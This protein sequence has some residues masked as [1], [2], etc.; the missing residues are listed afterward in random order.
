MKPINRCFEQPTL[1]LRI[2]NLGGQPGDRKAASCLRGGASLLGV[3][4]YSL[5][6]WIKHYTKPQ[7]QLTQE[8][9]AE[10]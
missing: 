1:I 5:Y 7:E 3:S 9:G 8:G 4:V 10:C 2:L 6:A